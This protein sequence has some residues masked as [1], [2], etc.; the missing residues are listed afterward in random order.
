MAYQIQNMFTFTDSGKIVENVK[1]NLP[2]LDNYDFV[3]NVIS[4]YKRVNNSLGYDFVST[5]S[6][7][8]RAYS[9]AI[10]ELTQYPTTYITATLT[11]WEKLLEKDYIE[12][13]LL[14]LQA[15]K[16]YPAEKGIIEKIEDKAEGVTDWAGDI[17]TNLGEGVS[18]LSETAKYLPLIL[19][20]GLG[21]YFWLSSKK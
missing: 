2:G 12:G 8:V 17:F 6:N 11:I 20:G 14:R 5:D 16:K 13:P 18:N 15:A 7:I 10:S 1:L 19:V 9:S 3:S 21:I 4:V